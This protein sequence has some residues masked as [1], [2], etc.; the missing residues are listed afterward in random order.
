MAEL[1]ITEKPQ[2]AKKIAEAVKEGKLN[3][4]DINEQVFENNLYNASEPD[5]IIRTSGEKRTSGFFEKCLLLFDG[6]RRLVP[7]K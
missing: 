7:G 4:D 5:L 2:A 3:V 6:N 1:I